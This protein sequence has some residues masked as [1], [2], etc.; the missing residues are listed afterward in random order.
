M[1][2]LA[3]FGVGIFIDV[4]PE[5]LETRLP[6]ERIAVLNNPKGLSFGELYRERAESYRAVADFILSVASGE[7]VEASLTHIIELRT[8]ASH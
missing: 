3:T 6:S 5:E 2:H 4:D 7:L 8:S 1:R